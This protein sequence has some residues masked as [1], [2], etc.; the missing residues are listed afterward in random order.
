MIPGAYDAYRVQNAYQALGDLSRRNGKPTQ[1]IFHFSPGD[2]L[3][4]TSDYLAKLVALRFS[5]F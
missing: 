2:S 5:L 3:G 4:V 1:A